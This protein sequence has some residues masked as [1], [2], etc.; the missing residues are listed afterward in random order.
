MSHLISVSTHCLFTWVYYHLLTQLHDLRAGGAEL[1][2]PQRAQSGR[3]E[4]H[5]PETFHTQSRTH[6]HASTFTIWPPPFSF[7]SPFFSPF[8]LQSSL[9]S[10]TSSLSHSAV[11]FKPRLLSCP[12]FIVKHCNGCS[13]SANIHKTKY[14]NT[15]QYAWLINQ[16]YF[17]NMG[18]TNKL[19]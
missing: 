3:D 8:T 1:Q 17:Y 14:I 9:H 11:C 7:M 13:L 12:L 16:A 5:G 18:S 4:R 15:T 6:I 19:Q 2:T 10:F